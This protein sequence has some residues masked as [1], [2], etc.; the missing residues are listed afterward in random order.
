MTKLLALGFVALAIAAQGLEHS[1][2]Q[3]FLQAIPGVPVSEDG[4]SAPPDMPGTPGGMYPVSIT[5]KCVIILTA[6]AACRTAADGFGWTFESSPVTK[7]LGQAALTVNY[8]PMASVM[9]LAIRMRVV[10]L[11]Q[12]AE[13]DPQPYVCTA[14]Q[15][16]AWSVLVATLVVCVIPLF[17]GE[18]VAADPKTGDID[19][20]A[21]PFKNY[22]VALGFTVLRYI[23]LAALYGGMITV[24]YATFDY[25]PANGN[26]RPMA[27][28][29]GATVTM[30]IM[31]FVSTAVSRSS[32][33]SP[34]LP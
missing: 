8:A 18:L 16:V 13:W 34:S 27:P 22:Y 19:E 32:G 6:L 25:M 29:V 10:W 1:P 31:F 17:T 4:V 9:F 24:I 28:A 3:Q 7:I 20:K 12:G 5:M 11:S 23:C 21:E 15:W 26:W 2:K 33:R 14:M 30:T